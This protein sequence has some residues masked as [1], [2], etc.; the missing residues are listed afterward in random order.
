MRSEFEESKVGP[1][2]KGR[3]YTGPVAVL[4]GPATF[5]A[6]EDFGAAWKMMKRGLTIGLP[7]GGSTGQPLFFNL[8]GG[9]GMRICTKRDRY[10][11]GNEFVGVGIQ[12]DIVVNTTLDDFRAGRD[13]VVERAV[14]ELLAKP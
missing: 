8:P 9:G 10:A 3:H 5:S 13:P 2:S 11:D 7:S 1:D 12:P 14:R 4:I 6:A